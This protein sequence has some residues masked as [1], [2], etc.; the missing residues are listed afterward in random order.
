VYAALAIF[1]A[2]VSTLVL[3]LPEELAL[4]GA[5]YFAH[6]GA[7]PL[8]AAWLAATSGNVVGDTVSYL[9][10]QYFLDRL[11]RTRVGRRMVSPEM[12]EWGEEFVRRHGFWAIILGR[13]LVALRGPVY[14]AIG[15][16]RVP[17]LRFE[18]INTA[19]AL[20]EGALLVWLGYEFGRS[21]R[22]AHEVRWIEI[23][24]GA[25]LLLGLAVPMLLKRRLQRQRRA[26]A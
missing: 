25:I 16:A 24:C 6:Q 22:L 15:A 19:V 21:S 1:G 4:M 3:P 12:R 23:A 13:F 17:F 9:I 8:W 26:A 18:A 2:V 5:G 10:G 14:F 20:V 7:L 11:L